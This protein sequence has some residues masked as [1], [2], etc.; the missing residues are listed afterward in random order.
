MHYS[1]TG[2]IALVT[3]ANRGIGKALT[4]EL[5][6]R[7]AKRV[8][9]TGR[10]PANL[11]QLAEDLNA[12]E[13][14]VTLPLDITRRED[15]EQLARQIDSLDILVNNAGITL[16][17]T[18]TQPESLETLDQEMATN[19][20]GP[21]HLTHALLPNLKRSN[22]AAVVFINSIAGLCNFPL[23]AAY[24]AAK[25]ALHSY[26]QG[27]RAELHHQGIQVLGVYPGPVATRLTDGFDGDKAEPSEVAR[28]IFENLQE[29]EEDVF[30]DAYSQAMHQIFVENPKKLEQTFAEA[31]TPEAVN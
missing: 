11:Q 6:N 28:I 19:F 5:L 3:G 26:T 1:I 24:A 15:I 29:R 2:K 30:P 7:G 16:G 10:D 12:P 13:R 14:L 18:F 8:Y 20:F 17:G 31:L 22:G 4:Q 25:A 27:L 21:V 23:I 9:A